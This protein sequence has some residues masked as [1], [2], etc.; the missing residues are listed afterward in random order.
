[1]LITQHRLAVAGLVFLAIAMTG[2]VFLI[3][4]VL[5]GTV[6]AAVFSLGV[7]GA[8]AWFW[9]GLPILRRAQDERTSTEVSENPSA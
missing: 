1:M 4:D 2:V 3:F 8:F 5:F 7:V 9:Y 6:T